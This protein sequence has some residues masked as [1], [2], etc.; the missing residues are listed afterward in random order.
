MNRRLGMFLSRLNKP[1]L[2]GYRELLNLTEEEEKVF[3]CLA[4]GKN[5]TQ[6]A[7]FCN[8]STTTIDNRIRTINEKLNRLIN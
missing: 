6:T 7:L 4:K 8:F 1:E 2:E 3:D 5:K